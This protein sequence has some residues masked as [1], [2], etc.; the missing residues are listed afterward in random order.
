[1]K[2]NLIALLIL[3]LLPLT[4]IFAEGEADIC[5]DKSGNELIECCNTLKGDFNEELA[6]DMEKTEM[7]NKLRACKEPYY[8]TCSK[9]RISEDKYSCCNLLN[10]YDE[11][12]ACGEYVN[13]ACTPS[14]SILMNSVARQVKIN[15]EPI[16]Q[17]DPNNEY[18]TYYMIDIKIYNLTPGLNVVVSNDSGNMYAVNP[19][20]N[21]DKNGIITL[22]VTETDRVKKFKFDI[23][24]EKLCYGKKLRTIDL[25]IPKYNTYSQQEICSDIPTFYLCREYINFDIDSEKFI[26]NVENYK[27]RI[28][29]KEVTNPDSTNNNVIN[30]TV[31]STF[32]TI[33]E[34]KYIIVGV[35]IFIGIIVTILI[36]RK[37]RKRVI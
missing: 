34:Y 31:D 12:R 37:H 26:E 21:A 9:E 29:K 10:D 35:I 23:E 13:F 25:T 3:L 19:D 2:K 20:L 18:I 27:K 24:S 7:R 33:S 17:V 14:D 30:T 5:K 15:Y 1:M 16:K 4:I 8:K 22:R 6:N 32:S 28:E 11:Q 36:I